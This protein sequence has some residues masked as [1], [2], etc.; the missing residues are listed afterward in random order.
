MIESYLQQTTY[1]ED[2]QCGVE[3]IL[4][5]HKTAYLWTGTRKSLM[6]DEVEEW[7]IVIDELKEYL[8]PKMT[9]VKVMVVLMV[10]PSR[11]SNREVIIHQLKDFDV[12]D[13]ID[14]SPDT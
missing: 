6:S 1:T 12:H 14:V 5:H 2:D 11:E 8:F 4:Q 13:K 7:H 9:V 3:S 10:L